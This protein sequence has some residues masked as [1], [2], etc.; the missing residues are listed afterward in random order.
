MKKNNNK[1]TP[2]SAQNF[3]NKLLITHTDLDGIGCAI[4]FLKCFPKGEVVFAEYEDVN[5]KVVNLLQNDK[6]WDILITDISVRPDLA[7][8]LDKRGKVGLLDHHA[9]ASWLGDKYQW[10]SIAIDQ[11][12]TR[13][14]YEMFKDYFH[15][16]DLEHFVSVVEDWDLW[17]RVSGNGAPGKEAIKLESLFRFYGKDRFINRALKGVQLSE[18][19]DEV[20][21][22]LWEKFNE[23]YEET[24]DMVQLH[25]KGGYTVGICVADQYQSLLG[26]RLVNDL[27]LEYVM[28]LDPRRGKG[29]LRGKGN[30]DLGALAKE[31]GGGGHRKAAGFP[32]GEGAVGLV[33][34]IER[35]D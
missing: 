20:A 12:G 24:F 10:A 8:L 28:I 31:A 30:I 5:E 2:I 7:E 6:D 35:E 34:N 32:L 15:L 27:N 13:M 19:D 16:E 25:E 18:H 26:H 33:N 4:V 21:N 17:G 14:I 11:C 9:T 1:V 29:S 3:T 23:Y 22:I